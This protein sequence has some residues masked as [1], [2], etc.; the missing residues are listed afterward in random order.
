M[1]TLTGLLGLAAAL[2]LLGCETQSV[3]FVSDL[4]PTRPTGWR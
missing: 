1:K 2:G 4:P 3:L